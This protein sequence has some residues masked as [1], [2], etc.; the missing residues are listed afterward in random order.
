MALAAATGTLG[1]IIPY[2][3]HKNVPTVNTTYMDKEMPEVS[4][5]RIVLTACGKNET[6]VLKAAIKPIISM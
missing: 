5:V 4:L 3:S 1:V 2:I 6:V